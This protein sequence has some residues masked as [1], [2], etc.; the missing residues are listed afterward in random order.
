M[1]PEAEDTRE[2]VAGVRAGDRA[3]VDRLFA[4]HRDALRRLIELR[5]DRAVRRRVDASDIV[6]ES[7]VEAHRRL[8]AY[9]AGDAMPFHL[10][11]RRIALD[12]IVDAHRR[13]RVARRRSV[14]RERALSAPRPDDRSSLDLLREL[15]DRQATPAAAALRKELARRFQGAIEQ[16]GDDDREVIVMR[17]F[18][19]LSNQEVATALELSEPAAGMRHLRAL[20]RL[21]GVL[22]ADGQGTSGGGT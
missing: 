17:H 4:R 6:Q 20:R 2:L 1:W 9:L 15:T 13:H 7:L 10:W 16:L 21:R 22:D 19:G 8:D 12:R 18:E 11:L 5:L 14:D 3:A